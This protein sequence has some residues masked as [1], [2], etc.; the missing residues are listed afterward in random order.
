MKEA[1]T[2]LQ[3]THAGQLRAARAVDGLSLRRATSLDDVSNLHKAMGTPHH[4]A[5]CTWN[6]TQWEQW[7]ADSRHTQ[8]LLTLRGD[9]IGALELAYDVD[10]SIEIVVFGLLPEH[11]GKGMGSYA[12]TLATRTAWKAANSE[13]RL[14]KRVWLLTSSLDHPSALPNYLRRGFSVWYTQTRE[15]PIT[16]SAF[17]PYRKTCPP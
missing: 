1:I 12:L 5:R 3:M 9:T 4:W 15:H 2:F 13:S 17:A 11:T 10:G 14:P 6:D 16:P 8:W 7:L